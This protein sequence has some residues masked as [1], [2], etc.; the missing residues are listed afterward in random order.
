MSLKTAFIAAW[1]V[2]LAGPL[3][4]QTPAPVPFPR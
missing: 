4:A 3:P 1:I 2:F